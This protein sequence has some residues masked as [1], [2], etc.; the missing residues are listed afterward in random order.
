VIQKY[1][2]GKYTLSSLDII[3]H[4]IQLGMLKLVKI[5]SRN[6]DGLGDYFLIK[7]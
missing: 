6:R 7:Q 3:K 5:P 2:E 1:Q 4:A